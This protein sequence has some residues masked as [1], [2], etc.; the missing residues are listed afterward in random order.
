LNQVFG[1]KLQEVLDGT[2]AINKEQGEKIAPCMEGAVNKYIESQM[3]Q[4]GAPGS[5]PSGA[6]PPSNPSENQVQP[7]NI[8]S[9]IQGPPD[10]IPS[11]QGPPA[12]I[13]NGAPCSSPEECMKMFGPQQ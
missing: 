5:M 10:N 1:G 12:N 7:D 3:P 4:G 6:L 9:G 8:P 11:G 2:V 13:P